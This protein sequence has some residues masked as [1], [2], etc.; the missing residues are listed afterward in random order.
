MDNKNKFILFYEKGM[1][2]IHKF[3]EKNFKFS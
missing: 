2:L 3:I 1:M